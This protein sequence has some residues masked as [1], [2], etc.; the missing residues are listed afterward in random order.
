MIFGLSRK[1]ALRE[2]SGV[3]HVRATAF[4]ATPSVARIRTNTFFDGA[5]TEQTEDA[6]ALH[7]DI[8]EK[9]NRLGPGE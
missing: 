2:T 5:A 8:C 6:D 4:S 9:G 1:R 3:L 7:A